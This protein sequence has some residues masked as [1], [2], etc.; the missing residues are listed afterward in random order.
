MRRGG[1]ILGGW[2]RM[3]GGLHPVFDGMQQRFVCP[4]G[5]PCWQPVPEE[6]VLHT[7]EGGVGLECGWQGSDA[8]RGQVSRGGGCA[9][10]PPAAVISGLCPLSPC[11]SPFLCRDHGSESD[12]WR[13]IWWRMDENWL[14]VASWKTGLQFARPVWDENWA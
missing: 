10:S 3:H 13:K 7:I 6:K 9:P 12:P 1:L 5:C 2:E 4:Q 8:Q 14:W 11:L